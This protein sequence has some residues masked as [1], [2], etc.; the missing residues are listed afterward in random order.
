MTLTMHAER[1]LGIAYRRDTG[2]E[3]DQARI[4]L[5]RAVLHIVRLFAQEGHSGGSASVAGPWLAQTLGRLL[6]Y[7][8]LTPL[9]GGSD[10]W[11][12]VHEGMAS[13]YPLQQNNRCSR[14]FRERQP[15]G[16]WI[17]FDIEVVHFVDLRDRLRR[18]DYAGY[19]SWD[20]TRRITFPYVPPSRSRRVTFR[21]LER[22]R[23]R[24]NRTL[25]KR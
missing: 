24:L 7:E 14:V 21:R 10:E 6:A 20:S 22:L 17:A 19:T 12:D 1:E 9:T 23:A 11:T 16:T 18:R 2:E 5:D 8:P 15:D 25:V 3:E 13:G 4:A